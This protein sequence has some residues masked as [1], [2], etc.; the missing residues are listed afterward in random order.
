MN[1][2][3]RAEEL[4]DV[5]T[6]AEEECNRVVEDIERMSGQLR[7]EAGMMFQYTNYSCP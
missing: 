2:K 5:L 4:F 7:E 1:L 3:N 6:K